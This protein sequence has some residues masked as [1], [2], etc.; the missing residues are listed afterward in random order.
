M[1]YFFGELPLGTE[2]EFFGVKY[3]KLG[4]SMAEDAN[5]DGHVFMGEA[6]VDVEGE[7]TERLPWKPDPVYWADRLSPAPGQ[8]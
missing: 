4:L 2:F 7:W 8:R 3:R 5:R 6:S 1:K